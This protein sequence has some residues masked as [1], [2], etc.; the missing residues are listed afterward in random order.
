MALRHEEIVQR[1]MLQWSREGRGRLFKNP[2]GKAWRG[3]ITDE[4][5]VDGR[6]V[7][8]LFDAVMLRYGLIAGSS[9]LIGWELAEYIDIGHEPVTLPIIC[10]IE[11]KTIAHKRLDPDQRNW[12]DTIAGIGGRAYLA[13]ECGDGY[14]LRKWEI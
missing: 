12:F 14:D 2:N 5:M 9:D 13:M 10:V 3:R 4:R 1:V 7:I 8:E 11:V 6:K